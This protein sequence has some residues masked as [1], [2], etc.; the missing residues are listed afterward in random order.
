M[1]SNWINVKTRLPEKDSKGRYAR[2]MAYSSDTNDGQ[3]DSAYRIIDGS[4]L[5]LSTENTW[6]M[7]LPAPPVPLTPIKTSINKSFWG[8]HETHC[9]IEHGCKYGYGDCP[10]VTGET[11]QKSKCEECTHPM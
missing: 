4:M 11:E 5:R 2:V 6:W 1:E 7:P 10:V 3:R 9:C 8:V